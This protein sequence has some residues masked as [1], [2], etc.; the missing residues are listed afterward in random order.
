MKYL[1]EC[2]PARGARVLLRL[3]LNAP[4]DEKGRIRDDFRLRRALPTLLFLRERGMRAIVLAH[5]ALPHETLRP[6]FALLAASL[7]QGCFFSEHAP[8]R[9]LLARAN[10][11]NE[12]DLL[13]LENIRRFPGE[14]N[15][16]PAFARE[17]AKAGE[18]FV[19]DAFASM[20]RPHASIVGLPL[21]LPSFGGL[22]VEEEI[23]ALTAA[24]APRHPSFAVV[25][26]AKFETKEPLIRLLLERFDRVA[27][28]G[29][30]AND[31]LKARGYEV[32]I[33]KVSGTLP[34]Q[35]LLRHPKLLIPR[36]VV[37]RAAG[38]KVRSARADSVRPDEQIVDIG[39][40]V[41]WEWGEH[42]RSASFVLWNGTMG[43][44]EEGFSACDKALAVSLQAS[45]RAVVGGGDTVA[46]LG[47][48]LKNQHVFLSTGGGAMLE[49]LTKGTLPG[50]EALEKSG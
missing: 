3:D 32:G 4:V 12:G 14:A 43:L 27:V 44:Y 17:L 35:A 36:E 48:S 16:D 11:L 15:N 1:R 5:R 46:V 8:G 19:D 40:Q 47:G 18:Y 42:M 34:S 21:L 10:D 45:K 13:F 31:F 24:R 25:G 29:A 2:P 30:L 37:V 50:I 39:I 9:E 28:G 20:H 49:F 38:G 41:G 6:A 33:S 23:A 7:G 22:L 26:G